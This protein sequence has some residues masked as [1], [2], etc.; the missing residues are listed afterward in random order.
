MNK[1]L[2][3]VIASLFALGATTSCVRDGFGKDNWDTPELVCNNKFGEPTKT[4]AEFV[5]MAPTNGTIEITD[6][7]IIDG[8]VVSSDENGNFYKTISFQDK[9][10]NPTIGLQIEINRT[11][12]YADFPVGAHIRINAK[13]LVLG[14]DRG[15]IKL[16]SKDP[17]YAIGRLP[18]SQVIN[19]LSIVCK[20]GKA[21][22]ATIK[23]LEL[24]GLAQATSTQY[25]NMLVTVPNV[26]FADSEVLGEDGVKNFIEPKTDTDRELIDANGG[27]AKLRTSQYA[28]FGA[29]KLPTGKGNI[30]FIVSRYNNN[31]QF[32]IRSTKDINFT[33]QRVDAA[34]AKGG[35]AL[36]YMTAGQVENFESYA[37]GASSEDFPK[38]YNDPIVGDRYWRV[39]QFPRNTGNK[40]IQFNFGSGTNHPYSKTYFVV[41]V[42]FDNMTQLSFKTKDGYNTDKT[43]SVLS[44]YYST[45]YQPNSLTANL[46]DIT[47]SFQIS[48]SATANGW[49]SN[50]TDS[51]VWNKPTDVKGKG[52][53]I[54]EYKGG[55]KLPTTAMQIDD[56]TIN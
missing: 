37:I 30:T 43:K 2:K 12:N 14:T 20:D 4:L 53:I 55:G 1:N 23:P 48:N 24:T 21:D 18:E 38:Y 34:T 28:K 31:W 17:E 39:A 25:L 54:F 42:D 3:F 49:G 52:Y 27:K 7:I 19:H 9:P 44:V 13:G 8:Y 46:T 6:D 36:S 26:Q 40:Y 47:S 11:S 16:G 22:I 10:E 32:F 29:E 35:S 15:V 33:E 41:P 45:D 50:F 5:S 56:I 51:G